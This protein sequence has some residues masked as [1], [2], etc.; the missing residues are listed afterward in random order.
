MKVLVD[1]HDGEYEI[2]ETIK[3]INE[4]KDKNDDFIGMRVIG[5]TLRIR[6]QT[7]A[8]QNIDRIQ[9]FHE[10]YPDFIVGHDIVDE[11]DKGNSLL[12]YLKTLLKLYKDGGASKIPAYFHTAETSWLDGQITNPNDLDPVSTVENTYEAILLGARRVGHGLGFIKHPYLLNLLRERDV[13]VEICPA[14][15]QIL[16][17][18][19]DLRNHPG[20]N[21]YRSG[22]PV[23]LG[24]DDPGSFGI[25]SFT[26][27][28]Y[29]VYMAWGVD[30]ADLK[31]LAIN[32]LNYS[33]LTGDEKTTAINVKWQRKWDAYIQS[34][35]SEACSTNLEQHTPSFA[36]ILPSSGSLDGGTPIHIYGRHFERAICKGV[37]CRFGDDIL[38]PG[39]YLSNQHITCV[40][41][42]NPSRV[43]LQL[44][45]FVSLNNGT[46]FIDTN[47]T[48]SYQHQPL[49]QC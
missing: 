27:D 1:L 25:D 39:E 38:V 26:V 46:T 16:G 34:V 28:W 5:R 13:A 2:N 12:F 43:P 14:S 29:E 42:P 31:Q 10:K 11:E 41:P 44:P 17:Y 30:L 21:Y 8:E 9:K 7:E 49:I 23:V 19:P 4:F 22:V 33:S 6:N 20:I 45:L 15:N 24:S 35:M 32:S 3:I 40:S 48:Y 47:M 37:V 36:S 18:I